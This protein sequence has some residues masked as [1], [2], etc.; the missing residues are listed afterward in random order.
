ME[1]ANGRPPGLFGANR[2]SD[3]LNPQ[4]ATARGMEFPGAEILIGQPIS[5]WSAPTALVPMI[6]GGLR[7]R[8]VRA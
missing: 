7:T 6:Q 3:V 4:F 5:K 1:Q 8:L 2:R